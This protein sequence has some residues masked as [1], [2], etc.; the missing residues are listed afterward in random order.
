M[1]HRGFVDSSEECQAIDFTTLPDSLVDM[2]Y[3]RYGK[4]LLDFSAS[5]AALL[6]F[7]PVMVSLYLV[8]LIVMGR[9]VFFGQVRGG[10]RNQP[11]TLW[12]FRSMLD[13]RDA[14]GRLLPDEDRLP[15]YGRLLRHSSLDELPNL[16]SVL[17]GD[18]SLVGPRPLPPSY[19][20]LYTPEQARRLDVVPGLVGLAGLHGRNAQPWERIFHYDVLYTH[21][22]RFLADL[23]IMI[24]MVG[25]IARRKGID[26]GEYNAG[27]AFAEKLRES[28]RA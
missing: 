13:L 4:R 3:Q 15:A 14:N 20:T 1:S 27:S 17:R 6:V 2:F 22:V 5:L 28:L 16:F 19:A 25:V 26:R 18:V 8:S 24:K 21:D 7:S 12:K 11:F 23:K 10:Y 9:P